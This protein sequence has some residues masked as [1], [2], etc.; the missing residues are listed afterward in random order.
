MSFINRATA[1]SSVDTGSSFLQRVSSI[2]APKQTNIESLVRQ[3][4][5]AKKISSFQETKEDPKK[6]YSGGVISDIFDT[7]NVLQ[8]GVVGMLK[9]KGFSEGVKTKQSWSDKDALGNFGIPGAIAGTLLDIAVDPFTYIAPLTIA[10]K[11]PGVAKGLD[12]AGSA[13]KATTI[14]K[15]ATKMGKELGEK[16]IYSMSGNPTVRKM[17][18]RMFNTVGNSNKNILGMI[19]GFKD[20]SEETASKLLTFDEFGAVIRRPLEEIAKEISPEEFSIVKKAYNA[21]DTM[22]D[23]MAK[24]NPAMAKVIAENKD[25]YIKNAYEEFELSKKGGMF[26]FLKSGVKKTYKRKILS[27]AERETLGQITNPAYL[28]GKSMLDMNKDIET[29]KLYNQVAKKFASG[30]ELPGYKQLSKSEKLLTTATSQK[31][32]L[33]GD[34]KDLHKKLVPVLKELK[35]VNKADKKLVSF[36]DNTLDALTKTKGIQID[37]LSKFINP[38]RV[39]TK[40]A[41]TARKIGT[42]PDALLGIAEDIKKFKNYD[43]FIKSDIGLKV[44][45]LFEEGVLERNNFTSIKNFFETVKKPFKKA[46]SKILENIPVG[47]AGKLVKLQRSI[48]SLSEKAFK[49]KNIDKSSID[50]SLN[51]LNKAVATLK[52]EEVDILRQAGNLDA[53]ELSGKFVPESVHKMLSE[54]ERPLTAVE[55]GLGKVMGSWKY[56]KVILNPAGHIRNLFSN[57][58]LN[59]WEGL[60]PHRIDIYAEGASDLAKYRKGLPTKWIKEVEEMGFDLNTFAHNEIGDLIKNNAGEGVSGKITN[61]VKGVAEKL[62]TAYGEEESWGK[63]SQYIFQRKSGKSINDAWAI[64]QRA[65]FD[66]SQVTPFV[67]RLRSSMFGFPFVT[68]GLKAGQ[69]FAKTAITHPGRISYIGKI[70]TAIE[71]QADLKELT[72]ERASQPPWVRDG[73]YIKLPIKDKAGRSAYFDMTYVLPFGDLVT[74][75]FLSRGI[76]KETG[77]KEGIP[78]ALI[79]KSP[80][81]NL[82]RELATN[83]DFSGNKIWKDSDDTHKQLADVS[84]HLL[85]FSLPP[86]ASDVLPGGTGVGGK[87]Q[88]STIQSLLNQKDLSSTQKRTLTQE[89]LRQFGV[90]ITP[91][92]A[93]VQDEISKYYDNKAMQTFLKESGLVKEYSSLYVPKK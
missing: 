32:L 30:V 75:Q 11:I 38:D 67:R 85:R 84:R 58:I 45:K 31:K 35:I 62:Q 49:L 19:N 28:L 1:K 20:F 10:K 55:K 59:S 82:I 3:P 23:S 44:E 78:S 39:G 65:T 48:E 22:S 5:I 72:R 77:L 74:G 76:D 81:I 50:D 16:L 86:S 69:Q 14:G 64:A 68:F 56:G 17:T 51:L 57:L 9:G 27:K 6:I 80:F 47:D 7:L 63:I 43:D 83:K 71:S 79:K 33:F 53:S 90:K 54:M 25:K 60:S 61:A 93:D 70:K 91:V 46:T 34:V 42:L 37:E 36:I 87:R 29:I 89:L 24:V 73:F 15:A 88:E 40:V 92:N 13:L 4:E 12:V 8:Y 66:Y 52:G 2:G 26:G 41:D 21:L 18:E